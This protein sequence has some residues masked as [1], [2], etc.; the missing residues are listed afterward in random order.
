MSFRVN[1][2]ANYGGQIVASALALLL[3]PLFVDQLGLEAWGLVGLLMVLSAWLNLVD[4]GLTPAITREIA[5][6]TPGE[7]SAV[8]AGQ[9]VCSVERV[10]ALLLVAIVLLIFVG[11]DTVVTQWLTLQQL[12]Q[13]DARLSVQ[14]MGAIVALRICENIYRSILTGLQELV[15][16]NLLAVFF[17]VV[18]WAGGL[19][20]VVSSD[21]GVV[22]LFVWQLGC[23]VLSLVAFAAIGRW[24]LRRLCP[25]PRVD[26]ASLHR[27]RGFASGIAAT[28]FLGFLLTQVDKLLLS[29]LLPLSDFGLYM[30]AVS[31]ADALALLAAPLYGALVPRFAQL[32]HACEADKLGAIYMRASQCL[33]AVLMPCAFLLAVHG[34]AVVLAWSGSSSL[35]FQL[36]P[37]VGLLALGRMLNALMQIP[38]A[39]QVA[40]GWTSLGAQLNL[41]AVVVL[42]PLI[43]WQVPQHGAMAYA[44]CWLALNAGYLTAGT[45]LMH[46]R[47]LPGLLRRWLVQAVAI[48][49][50]ASA[51]W[52]LAAAAV[53]DWPDSRVGLSLALT[54]TLLGAIALMVVLMPATRA[55]LGALIPAPKA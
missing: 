9:L 15:T 55:M 52:M 39:L 23:A 48:P 6:A 33:A 20:F 38:A 32:S 4:V 19:L 7:P 36:A 47:L 2:L 27:I 11:A 12:S 26:Y 24:R 53:F 3:A 5:R 1:V 16:L 34:E 40:A 10:Y 14:L 25:S 45:W 37:L 17:A 29:R 41:F 42:V 22:G 31:L 49:A 21:T 51:S 28:T 18:R 43:L 46:R 30:L 8:R 35:A 50:V 44:W 13:D 54:S